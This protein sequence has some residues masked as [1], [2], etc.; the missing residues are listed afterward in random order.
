[1]IVNY[2]KWI[3]V[4]DWLSLTAPCLLASCLLG[5]QPLKRPL[6]LKLNVLGRQ[7][8]GH[9][10]QLSHRP[11]GH[12]HQTHVVRRQQVPQVVRKTTETSVCAADIQADQT[13]C[14]HGQ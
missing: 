7:G 1:M 11:R 13:H 8:P 6:H 2:F 5:A 9:K 4:N 3:I 10:G 14:K 12:L